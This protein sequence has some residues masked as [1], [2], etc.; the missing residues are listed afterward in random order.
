M[1][2]QRIY[3]YDI[4]RALAVFGMVIV[5]FKTVM[6]T[7][8]SNDDG[9][10]SIFNILDGRASAV[11]VIL[12]GVGITLMTQGARLSGSQVR[13]QQEKRALLKR[14]AF[15]FITG[16]LYIEIWPADILHYYGVYISL[17]ALL[18]TASTRQLLWVAA[19]ISAGFPIIFLIIDYTT[20]WNWT[21]LHYADFWSVHGFL[22]NLLF[23]GFHPVFPWAAFL[24]V[25]MAL[26]R[27]PMNNARIRNRVF[28]FGLLAT[29]LIEAFSFGIKLVLVG[30]DYAPELINYLFS[31]TPMPPLP[32]YFLSA[33]GS[34]CVVI[35][36]S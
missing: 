30:N 26:G 9:W 12:A 27:L 13:L 6:H 36:L 11:F 19:A 7:N 16:L 31:T 14:A 8:R 33:I 15:L 24:L 18:L 20:S 29:L 5:N 17:G 3:G 22:R 10:L 2:N 32:L 34:S 25:G 21:T 28:I 4:A 23:N 1:I 35:S